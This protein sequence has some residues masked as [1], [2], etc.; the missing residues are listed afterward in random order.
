MILLNIMNYYPKF[1]CSLVLECKRS[2]CT[3]RDVRRETGDERRRYGIWNGSVWALGFFS[4]GGDN[5][6]ANE[7]VE[8]GCSSLH[9]LQSAQYLL[10][11]IVGH[12][13]KHPIQ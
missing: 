10:I 1:T 4:S 6:K 13:A 5:I 12:F 7:G 3:H 2:R 8:T 11:S 9:D